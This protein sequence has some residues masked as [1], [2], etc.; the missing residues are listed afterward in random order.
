MKKT[1]KITISGRERELPLCPVNE[2]LDIAALIMFGDVELTKAA[3][4]DLL[5][6]CP[7]FDIIITAEAKGIPLCYEM[8]RQSEK[9]YVVAR[10]ST[11][12][13]M[14]NSIKASVKSI[15]T[16]T[17]QIVYL[18]ETEVEMLKGKKV[19]IVD[20]VISTG[21]SLRAIEELVIKAE[22]HIEARAC[23]LA[24]GVSIERKDIISLGN[25]PLF[26]KY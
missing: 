7:D 9:S 6:K 2:K 12:V 15:T 17:E 19:L 8:A 18:G 1:Y 13:Y 16:Q 5:N 14:T 25:L 23:V 4:K 22:G 11:K 21:D 26:F 10:K 24:E 20:D 3:A